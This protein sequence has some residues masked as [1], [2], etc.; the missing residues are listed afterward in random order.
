MPQSVSID[1]EPSAGFGH[2]HELRDRAG[3]R[4]EVLEDALAGDAVEGG[5]VEVESRDVAGAELDR[6]VCVAGPASRFV[7]HR[8]ARFDTDDRAVGADEA[9]QG[10]H[11][12]TGAAADVEQPVPEPGPEQLRRGGS[13]PLDGGQRRLLVQRGDRARPRPGRRRRD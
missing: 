3:G 9:S 4:V 7:E 1:D 2:P 8:R 12:L 5:V 11:D 13:Q 10:A 6:K